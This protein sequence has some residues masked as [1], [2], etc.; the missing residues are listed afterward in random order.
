[1]VGRGGAGGPK[2]V[3][4]GDCLVGAGPRR[5][6]QQRKPLGTPAVAKWQPGLRVLQREAALVAAV[7]R[8]PVGGVVEAVVDSGAEESVAP[9]GVFAAAVSPS[10]MSRAGLRYRAANGSRI[11]NVGQQRVG[12]TTSEGHHAVMPFQVAEVERPLISVAQLTSA[13]H[14]VVLGETGGQIVHEKSGRT[15]ELV[16]RGDIYLLMMIEGRPP[17]GAA[18][19]FPRQG[20]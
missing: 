9:P 15:I 17:S 7:T 20:K 8:S 1:M 5:S 14:R 4:L 11:R 16:R 19:G 13:G 2:G 10:K 12:F 3:T 18:S 6:R